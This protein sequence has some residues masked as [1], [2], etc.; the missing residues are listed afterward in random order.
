AIAR[1][2]HSGLRKRPIFSGDRNGSGQKRS[3]PPTA[4]HPRAEQTAQWFRDIEKGLTN[5][6]WPYKNAAPE[7]IRTLSLLI[8]SKDDAHVFPCIPIGSQ[9]KHHRVIYLHPSR[10]FLV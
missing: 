2:H 8:R 10:F 7:E 3:E 9:Y 1:N 6:S 4:R 5:F